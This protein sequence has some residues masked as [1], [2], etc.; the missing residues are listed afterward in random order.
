MRRISTS[1]LSVALVAQAVLA[2]WLSGCPIGPDLATL[3]CNDAACAPSHWVVF[4]LT[5]GGSD[6][7]EGWRVRIS[8]SCVFESYALNVPG[9]T[10]DS[11]P[12]GPPLRAVA[13]R[14]AVKGELA[15]ARA[16]GGL[17]LY[18]LGAKEPKQTV[19]LGAVGLAW[20]QDGQKLAVVTRDPNRPAEQAHQLGIFS[21]QL[22]ELDRFALDLPLSDRDRNLIHE[23]FVVSW[24]ADDSQ[25]AVSTTVACAPEGSA[26][27]VFVE[28]VCVVV[29]LADRQTHRLRL[30]DAYFVGSDVLVTTM[31]PP[32]DGPLTPPL[33]QGRVAR[34]RLSDGQI[35]EARPLIG[36]RFV[37]A[38]DASAGVFVAIDPLITTLDNVVSRTSLRT[39]DG[40]RKSPLG[41]PL[42]LSPDPVYSGL[43]PP[44][45][46]PADVGLPALQAAGLATE[47]P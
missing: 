7:T 18:D 23:R 20:S 42:G 34:V 33:L 11:L 6:P 12:P 21:P 37:L 1:L 28:P 2:V 13:A 4:E 47:C 38:S 31:P 26:C 17:L 32:G 46:V 29:D 16:D 44:S 24:N 30:F 36:P 39:A 8:A 27:D 3:P 35:V 22:D 5:R 45:V 41:L 40:R 19:V 43:L 14:P 9:E 15:I 25:I 10:Q